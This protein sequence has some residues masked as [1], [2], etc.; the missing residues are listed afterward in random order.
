VLIADCGSTWTKILES[1]SGKL[2]IIPTKELVRRQGV[3]FEMATGHA[4]RGRCRVFRNELMALAEGGLALVGHGDFSLVDVGGRDI[5][6]VRMRNRRVER[7]D[8][9]LACG[10]MTGATIELLGAYYDVDFRALQPSERWIDVTCGVFG[11]ERV[12]EQ[13]SLGTPAEE[14]VARFIHGFV[15]AVVDF[16]GRP[17]HFYLSGG[18]CENPCFLETAA[19]YSRVT[20]L[21]RAVL[22]EGL[23][24]A[25]RAEGGGTR[26]K[27]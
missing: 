13:V 5:K 10:S 19:R 25:L 16:V 3:T 9:N 11:M 18:F 21:G 17:E 4:A 26:T 24:A 12:L 8:W 7:L 1:S 27:R 15:R 14:S 23:S 2:E 6:F 20:P 22:I